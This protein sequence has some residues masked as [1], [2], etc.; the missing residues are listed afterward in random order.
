VGDFITEQTRQLGFLAGILNGENWDDRG[1]RIAERVAAIVDATAAFDATSGFRVPVFIPPQAVEQFMAL[2]EG[3]IFSYTI[4]RPEP[5][6]QTPAALHGVGWP[7]MLEPRS[8]RPLEEA[9]VMATYCRGIAVRTLATGYF[10]NPARD[11]LRRCPQCQRWFVDTTR[12][13]S[14]RRC[15]PDCTIA[16]SNAQR[17]KKRSRP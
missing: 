2:Q 7:V 12:N 13:K 1:Y 8:P 5:Q 4:L 17:V 6:P 14:A 3:L 15:S 11:R 10:G 9:E 16:W